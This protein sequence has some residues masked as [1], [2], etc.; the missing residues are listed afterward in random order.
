MKIPGRRMDEV[1]AAEMA[2]FFRRQDHKYVSLSLRMISCTGDA[3]SF[4]KLFSHVYIAE[5]LTPD[6]IRC[7]CR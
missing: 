2:D 1:E 6:P 3:C 7:K 5:E 4:A